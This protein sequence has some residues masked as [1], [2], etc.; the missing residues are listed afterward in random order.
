LWLRI[1]W[2]LVC[3]GFAATLLVAGGLAAVQTAAV[4]AAMPLTV[5]M[6]AIC[7]GLWKALGHEAQAMRRVPGG[8]VG[9]LITV[10]GGVPW[11]RRL[12]AIASPPSR[13]Q[14]TEFI[15][16]TVSQALHA[17]QAELSKRD[18]AASLEPRDDGVQLTVR[19]GEV[20]DFVYAVVAA[21]YPIPAFAL[22]DA[23]RREGEARRYF[24]AEV[25]LGGAQRGYDIYGLGGE[26]VKADVINHYDRFRQQLH[27]GA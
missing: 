10:P 13:R 17:V 5:V 14:V 26:Q 6:L 2:A 1:F 21:G 19:H 18:L 3:G 23:A 22:T 15:G 20:A 8:D 27:S 11:Q 7:A 4:I 12:G 16:G 9:P 25:L 24:R